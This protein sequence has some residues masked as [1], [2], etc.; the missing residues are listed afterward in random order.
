ME[1]EHK[2]G[3]REKPIDRW[4]RRLRRWIDRVFV[5]GAPATV[6]LPLKT[7]ETT[8]VF[9]RRL[10]CNYQDEFSTRITHW[11]CV[12]RSAELPY[13]LIVTCD[14]LRRSEAARLSGDI[15]S[16]AVTHRIA[17][18]RVG[19]TLIAGKR[20]K[21]TLL[22]TDLDAIGS[23]MRFPD[24][25]APQITDSLALQLKYRSLTD[26]KRLVLFGADDKDNDD[27]RKSVLARWESILA[28]YVDEYL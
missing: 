8:L 20:K 21:D 7:I 16:L 26:L 13:D 1:H 28:A 24:G 10:D 18:M 17:V 27:E 3:R 11:T 2:H 23:S 5:G 15:T 9:L 22:L 6:S 14:R 19:R 25:W 12:F 4:L